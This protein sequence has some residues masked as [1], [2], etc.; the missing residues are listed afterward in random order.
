V[1]P[2]A[3]RTKP[4]RDSPMNR[5]SNRSS[6]SRLLLG[7]AT[8]LVLMLANL[9]AVGP[10]GAQQAEVQEEKEQHCVA[11]LATSEKAQREPVCFDSIAEVDAL[12]QTLSTG[13]VATRAGGNTIGRH[14]KNTWYGGS[15]ITI[16]GT[17]CSGGVWWPTGSWNDNI[18]SSYNYCGG[19]GTRFYNSS[20]CSSSST[21][22]YGGAGSLGWM[23][24]KASCVR[25]G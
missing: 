1:A 25:Y 23:N 9:A 10:A 15:S 3:F 21:A 22:I 13:N 11:N 19:S 16:T 8:F 18:E 17:T 2:A 4:K 12:V 20:S 5:P 7:A 14:F 24:N 6:L